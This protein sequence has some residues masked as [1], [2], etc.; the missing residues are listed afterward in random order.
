VRSPLLGRFNVDNLL[1]VAFPSIPS[2]T[3]ALLRNAREWPVMAFS[4][5][6][7]CAEA[8]HMLSASRREH[9]GCCGKESTRRCELASSPSLSTQKLAEAQTQNGQRM[10]R[11]PFY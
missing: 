3:S 7:Q 9:A 10:T 8:Q 1:A 2:R 4:H 6:K 5:R 11:W